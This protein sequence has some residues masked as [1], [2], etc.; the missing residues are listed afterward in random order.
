MPLDTSPT[1]PIRQ[2]LIDEA[3]KARDWVAVHHL[4]RGAA[5]EAREPE[6][7]ESDWTDRLGHPR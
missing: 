7:C 5:G 1:R 3:I 6:P 4:M 2:R